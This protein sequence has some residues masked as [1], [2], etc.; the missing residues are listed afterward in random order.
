MGDA[1]RTRKIR[2]WGRR[3]GINKCRDCKYYLQDVKHCDKNDVFL[4]H[5]I[6]EKCE[7]YESI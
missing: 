6:I 2:D 7:D 4:G 3:S 5:K 1:K